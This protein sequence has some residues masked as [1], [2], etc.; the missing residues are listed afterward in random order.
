[1]TNINDIQRLN[2]TLLGALNE[3]EKVASLINNAV[4]E[5]EQRNLLSIE[6]TVKTIERLHGES[7]VLH[8]K[9]SDMLD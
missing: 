6:E 3:L 1:M 4:I 5:P 9:L 7:L 2:I 8:A